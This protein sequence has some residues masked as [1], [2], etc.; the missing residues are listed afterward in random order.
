VFNRPKIVRA[1][2][3]ISRLVD[4]VRSHKVWAYFNLLKNMQVKIV[5]NSLKVIAVGV[6]ITW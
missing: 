4:D 1:S 3:T 5:W 2:E 6:R